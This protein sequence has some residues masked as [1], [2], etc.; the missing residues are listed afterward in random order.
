[1]HT[2]T[3]TKEEWDYLYN[4]NPEIQPYINNFQEFE[5]V[6]YERVGYTTIPQKVVYRTVYITKE[7]IEK[8]LYYLPQNHYLRQIFQGYV[9]VMCMMGKWR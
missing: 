7:G 5:A 8:I 3:L 9:D 1:M 2:I 4:L 6:N